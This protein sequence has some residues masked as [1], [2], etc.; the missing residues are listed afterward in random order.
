MVGFIL[1]KDFLSY[2]Q[3]YPNHADRPGPV[4]QPQWDFLDEHKGH[5]QLLCHI[6]RP[7]PTQSSDPRFDFGKPMNPIPSDP[8]DLDRFGEI[9]TLVVEIPSLC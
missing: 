3:K 2:L 4:E 6:Q 7:L 9:A 8:A 5:L 1:P